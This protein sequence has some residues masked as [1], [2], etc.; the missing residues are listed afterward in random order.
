MNVYVCIYILIHFLLQAAGLCES[1]RL[2]MQ[3]YLYIYV[4]VYVCIYIHISIYLYIYI[5]TIYLLKHFLL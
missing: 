5:H 2:V 3:I 4:C 1:S